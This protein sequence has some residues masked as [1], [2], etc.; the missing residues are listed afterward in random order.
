MSAELR[1][2]AD[3]CDYRVRSFTIY[4][5]NGYRFHTRSHE[6]RLPNRK[7][8]NT[9]VFT[10]GVDG[11]EC[12]GRIKEIYKLTFLGCIP[13]NPVIFKYHWFDPQVT[14]LTPN[15]G[16]VEIRQD[17]TILEED[18][19][20]A[21]QQATQVYYLPYPCKTDERLNGWDVV[22]KVS[23]HGQ[24][25]VPNNEDY[26]FDP[27]TYDREFFQEDW[28]EETFEIDLT[29]LIE[30]E[31]DNERVL[32]E[33]DGD[34]VQNMKDLQLLERLNLDNDND[35]NIASMDSDEYIDMADSDDETYD[36]A[37]PDPD[38]YF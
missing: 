36:P 19:Y 20:I 9:R 6:E 16:L 32:V 31:V 27:N 25:P 1:Q 7:T 8:T 17:S 11:V 28:L 5:V 22:Y 26:N 38:D 14:R 33:D 4:D 18:V 10:A 30:M 34:E 15:L 3:G 21:A 23:P 29:G 12:Y 37:N 35:E 24:L 13:L 2:V